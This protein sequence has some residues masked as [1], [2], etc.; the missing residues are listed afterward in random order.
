MTVVQQ[1]ARTLPEWVDYIEAMHPKEIALGLDRIGTV[2]ER[3][4]IAFDCP[5]VIVGGTNGKG[6]TCMMLETIWRTAGYR[7]GQYTSPH[8]H[9]F[10]ERIRIDGQMVSDGELVR[11]FEAVEAVRGDV[12]LTFFE[13]TT[14]VAMKLFAD[15]KLDV[16]VLEVGLGGRFDAVNLLD[17]D[18]AVVTNVAIDHVAFL[19]GTREKIGFEKAGIYRKGRTALY[20]ELDPPQ[21]LLDHAAAIGADLKRYGQ[22]YAGELDGGTWHYRGPDGTTLWE[23]PRP[24]LYGDCQIANAATALT[25]VHA[26]RDRLPVYI[27]A[28]FEALPQVHLPGR[29]EV[30]GHNPLV[31]VDVA[32]NPHAAGTLSGNLRTS[33]CKGR[34][35]AVYGAMADKDIN[36]V[37]RILKDQVDDW[38][39]TNLPLPRAASVDVLLTELLAAGVPRERIVVCEEA[40]KAL[41]GARKNASNDDR[42]IAFGSFWVVTGVT[43]A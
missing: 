21:S 20:G 11:A 39:I 40:E 15:A 17:A 1:V 42:I 25:A 22:D 13:F 6:S 5:V 43:P 28:I 41:A 33:P 23:L 14:L 9:R 35:L 36:G 30:I 29:V 2:K 34:T 8:I 27:E 16:V 3:L 18:V 24:A 37:V 19:G 12:P 7:V 31:I 26:L 32:H 4:A 10:N 38:Y